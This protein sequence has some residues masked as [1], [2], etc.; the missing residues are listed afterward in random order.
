MA[1]NAEDKGKAEAA[2]LKPFMEKL[3][4]QFAAMSGDA[5]EIQKV[6]KSNAKLKDRESKLRRKK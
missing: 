4:K 6:I 1:D 3:D 5:A 2:K